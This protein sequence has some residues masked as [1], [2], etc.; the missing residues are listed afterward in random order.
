MW[1]TANDV[2]AE[3]IYVRG[4]SSDQWKQKEPGKLFFE[5][6]KV[7]LV[8]QFWW[9][10]ASWDVK[11]SLKCQR[12]FQEN[13]IHLKKT[14]QSEMEIPKLVYLFAVFWIGKVYEIIVVHLLGIDDV[15]V[16]FLTEILRVNSIGS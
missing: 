5:I 10:N 7:T 13:Y 9:N 2:S 4:N 6:L 15:T 14:D 16:L 11:S 3:V 12:N 1:C 8:A